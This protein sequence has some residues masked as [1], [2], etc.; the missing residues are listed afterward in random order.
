MS[1]INPIDQKIHI[2]RTN[3]VVF[4]E[5][6]T[7]IAQQAEDY[8]AYIKL[9]AIALGIPLAYLVS[10]K[11]YNWMN[12]EEKMVI[13]KKNAEPILSE[14]KHKEEKNKRRVPGIED[15]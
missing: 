1:L 12:K 15:F 11:L 8:S 5:S 4:D 3:T 2:G 10:K 7:I 14:S 6:P 13:T 9:G